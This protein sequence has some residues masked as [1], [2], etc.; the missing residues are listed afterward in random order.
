[1]PQDVSQACLVYG[2]YEGSVVRAPIRR[3]SLAQANAGVCVLAQQRV[4][5]PVRCVVVDRKSACT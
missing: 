1:M 4:F 5:P 2:L 3:T